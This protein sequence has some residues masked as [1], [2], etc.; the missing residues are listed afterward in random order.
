MRWMSSRLPADFRAPVATPATA[1]DRRS[2]RRWPAPCSDRARGRDGRRKV[3]RIGRDMIE[4]AETARERI[5]Q[6]VDQRA[7]MVR[8]VVQPGVALCQY[9]QPG[10]N[11]M[12]VTSQPGTARG[13]AEADGADTR[14]EIEHALAPGRASTA[15]A[16]STAST[17]IR[18][19]AS[20]LQ[21]LHAPA[22][23]SVF[24]RR[25]FHASHLGRIHLAATGF[26]GEL[27]SR[28]GN[29]RLSRGQS[30][31]REPRTAPVALH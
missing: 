25:G 8:G 23:H 15:A 18:L 17:A 20:R 21:E 12:P 2:I 27:A 28:H 10:C 7:N 11:S 14:S 29:R 1:R 31:S 16:N 24:G 3:G 4:R 19:S 13:D 26:T 5:R 9:R 22:H 30:A 6:I